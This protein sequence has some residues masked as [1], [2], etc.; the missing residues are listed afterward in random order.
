MLVTFAGL[1]GTGKTTV[2]KL[3]AEKFHLM[4]YSTGALFREMAQEYHMTLVEFSDY[5]AK[6]KKIDIKL[7]K[8]MKQLGLKGNA[9]L[10]GQLCWYFL[11]NEADWK[12]LL[13]CDEMTRIQRIFER[14]REVKG[15]NIT[16]ESARKETLERE[17]IEQARYKD[18]YG[19]DLSDMDFVKRNHNIVVDTTNIGI[20]DVVE[21]IVAQMKS[22]K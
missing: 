13:T 6:H 12:V 21:K 9:V 5:A 3:I 18:I 15:G 10:D 16:L 4:H 8:K 20:N 14:D 22:A 7:D 2:A 1:H 19:I 17:R 11:K